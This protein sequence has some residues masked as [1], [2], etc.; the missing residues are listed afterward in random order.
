MNWKPHT[1]TSAATPS[2]NEFNLVSKILKM[3]NL[4]KSNGVSIPSSSHCYCQTKCKTF[5]DIVRHDPFMHWKSVIKTNLWKIVEMICAAHKFR[6]LNSSIFDWNNIG[7]VRK[8]NTYN[9]LLLVHE[10]NHLHKII[11]MMLNIGVVSAVLLRC[12]N[13]MLWMMM[14]MMA[15]ITPCSSYIAC[16]FPSLPQRSVILE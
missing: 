2:W 5:K 1:H 14:L 16:F 4:V 13:C 3:F 10:P 8:K 11:M 15:A 6:S 12:K 9:T 7:A